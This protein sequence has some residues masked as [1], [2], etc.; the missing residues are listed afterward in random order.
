MNINDYEEYFGY[1]PEADAIIEEAKTKLIGLLSDEV[2]QKLETTLK[3]AERYE[4]IHEKCRSEEMR[5]K[6]IEN[7]IKE[8]EERL[9]KSELYDMP[10]KYAQRFVKDVLGDFTLGDEVYTFDY[11]RKSETCPM[12]KGESK[13]QAIA[14]GITSEIKCPKC[15]G[16]GE[17]TVDKT[18]IKK[19]KISDVDLK[20]C[21]HKDRTSYWSRENI[22][23]D[24]RTWA[25]N[26]NNIFA[27][28]EE[29]EKALAE[30]E[31]K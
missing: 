3:E 1:F 17:A 10:K 13:I 23:L 28:Q 9:E 27:T 26:I 31:K 18:I 24:G 20:L 4:E 15:N 11:I 12:C 6:R 8:A 5:L 19:A 29:A 21:F 25:T 7:A 16:L 14:G 2:K 30:R 22:Y